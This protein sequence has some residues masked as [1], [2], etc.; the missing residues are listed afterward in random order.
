MYQLDLYASTQ[1]EHQQRAQAARLERALLIREAFAG[2]RGRINIYQS[3]LISVGKRLENF[4]AALQARY[5]ER[6]T[7][8][9]TGTLVRESAC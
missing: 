6:E 3:A 9:H 5:S 1:I 7:S 8:R 4:G 2:Q